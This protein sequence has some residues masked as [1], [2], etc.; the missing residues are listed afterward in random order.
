MWQPKG[1][2]PPLNVNHYPAVSDV[3]NRDGP[4]INVFK[5]N[6]FNEPSVPPVP[7]GDNPALLV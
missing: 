2:L 6:L 1:Q 3:E 4:K 7:N 5:G